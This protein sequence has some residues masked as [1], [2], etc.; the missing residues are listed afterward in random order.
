MAS[1][2]LSLSEMSGCGKSRAGAVMLDRFDAA[3][4]NG[5]TYTRPLFLSIFSGPIR[6]RY[7]AQEI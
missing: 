3:N 5:K 4:T 7:P 6:S 2:P 1:E